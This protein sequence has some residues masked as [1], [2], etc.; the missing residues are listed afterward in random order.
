MIA[1]SYVKEGVIR[2]NARARLV[3]DGKVVHMGKIGSVRRFKEDVREVGVN[4]E[5]G[6]GLENYGDVKNG[7]I[8][9]AFETAEEAATLEK[10]A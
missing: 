1:G 3:R 10:N 2:R 6:I 4:F 8:I 9:E 7:D 5:C